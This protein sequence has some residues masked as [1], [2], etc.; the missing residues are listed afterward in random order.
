MWAMSTIRRDFLASNL[1]TQVNRLRIILTSIENEDSVD[2]EYTTQSLKEIEHNIR[3]L[4]KVCDE[5]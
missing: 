3:Q 1:R 4:R 2:C 5:Q